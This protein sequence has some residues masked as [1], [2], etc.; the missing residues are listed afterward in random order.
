MYVYIYIYIKCLQLQFVD[1]RANQLLISR[2]EMWKSLSFMTVFRHS[3]FSRFQSTIKTVAAESKKK[4][5]VTMG[6]LQA[7]FFI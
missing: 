1:T 2:T 5:S 6:L 4:V 7:P 3:A